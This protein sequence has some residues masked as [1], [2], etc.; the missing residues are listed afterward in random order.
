[1][2]WS[3]V[4]KA[5][6]LSIKQ[7]NRAGTSLALTQREF[8]P[9]QRYPRMFSLVKMFS[10]LRT[11]ITHPHHVMERELSFLSMG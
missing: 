2:A 4:D 11:T 3:D 5:C 9:L 8:C 1:M 7:A 10:S 6:I